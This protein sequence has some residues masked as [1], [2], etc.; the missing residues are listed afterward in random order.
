MAG[1]VFISHSHDGGYAARLAEHLESAGLRAWYDKEIVHGDRWENT[2]REMVDTCAAL[3]VV[4]TPAADESRWVHNE[5]N[6]AEQKGKPILP[7]LLAGER[8]FS[9]A[10]LQ[11]DD[12]RGGKLP[13]PAFLSRLGELVAASVASD[14]AQRGGA[15]NRDRFIQGLR[16]LAMKFTE[17]FGADHWKTL[18]VRHDLGDWLG[19]AGQRAEAVRILREVVAARAQTLGADHADTLTSRHVLAVN[20]HETAAQPE[21]IQML[22]DVVAARTRVLGADHPDTLTSRSRLGAYLIAA[23]EHAAAIPLLRDTYAAM[24]RVLGAD[25]PQTLR[26]QSL[27]AAD[28]AMVGQRDDAVRL[29]RDVVAARAR[30]AGPD[31]PDTVAARQALRAVEGA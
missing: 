13:G 25:G 28:L 30:T 6:Q 14:A 4:M 15:F 21:A 3:V 27:L 2:I 24:T 9:L 22:R 11:Y 8:F 7:L 5:I 29:L 18:A 10:S 16:D 12:V 1:H 20:L 19:N 31:H 26:T 23:G 17:Q